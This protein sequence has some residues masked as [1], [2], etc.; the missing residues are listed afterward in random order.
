MSFVCCFHFYKIVDFYETKY[1]R[2][3]QITIF[4]YIQNKCFKLFWKSSVGEICFHLVIFP[5]LLCLVSP[6]CSSVL[7]DYLATEGSCLAAEGRIMPGVNVL[8]FLGKKMG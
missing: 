1:E 3:N 2:I 6:F 8:Y 7:V 5:F 4:C